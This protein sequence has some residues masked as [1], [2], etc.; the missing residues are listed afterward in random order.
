MDEEIDN[1][2]SGK[3]SKGYKQAIAE[4]ESGLDELMQNIPAQLVGNKED[5][6][7]GY[8]AAIRAMRISMQRVTKGMGHRKALTAPK[9]TVKVKRTQ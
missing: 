8:A 5:F 7:A 2:E 9:A 6:R 3:T 1:S 4:V